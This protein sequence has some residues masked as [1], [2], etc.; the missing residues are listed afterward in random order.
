MARNKR[1]GKNRTHRFPGSKRFVRICLQLYFNAVKTNWKV[2]FSFYNLFWYCYLNREIFLC[3]PSLTFV[4][5]ENRSLRFSHQEFRF[6]FS[7][8]AASLSGVRKVYKSGVYSCPVKI[9][10]KMRIFVNIYSRYKNYCKSVGELFLFN[11]TSFFISI[12]ENNEYSL[13]WILTYNRIIYSPVNSIIFSS[14]DWENK[15]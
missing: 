6:Y 14:E 9:I 12:R 2:G 13:L 15:K 11:S 8:P 4:C 10:T 7:P 3:L 1:Y 5:L